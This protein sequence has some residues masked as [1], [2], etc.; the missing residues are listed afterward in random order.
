M[1]D[2]PNNY[3]NPRE[4]ENRSGVEYDPSKKT[5]IF[6][7]D[8][9][10]IRDEL[11]AIEQEL[12]L[13]PRSRARVYRTNTRQ[14]IASDT[15][16]KVQFNAK[17]Y[18]NQNEFDITNNYRFTPKKSGYYL[19]IAQ[20]HWGSSVDQTHHAICTVVNGVA[21]DSSRKRSSGTGYFTQECHDIVYLTPNDYLEL[22]V[23]QNSGGN[24]NIEYGS[25]ETYMA[26]HK[27]SPA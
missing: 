5:V 14:T 18:D 23:Y 12:G 26:I 9:N 22:Y 13:T 2:Y 3:F 19:V 11:I 8:L 10:A 17:N 25:G 4:K 21:V 1:A 24:I 16:T 6:V 20:V 27:L 15:L 7:E